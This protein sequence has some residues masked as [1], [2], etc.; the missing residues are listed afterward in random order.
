MSLQ[1][2]PRARTETEGQSLPTHVTRDKSA[3]RKLSAKRVTGTSQAITASPH[4]DHAVWR[5]PVYH[6]GETPSPPR[7]S[8]VG[9]GAKLQ[10]QTS[11]VKMSG[12]ELRL[13]SGRACE[14][15]LNGE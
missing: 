13:P 7:S 1:K 14:L 12:W 4:A 6:A 9:T 5:Q 15:D 2:T 3:N 10:P 11:A 8:P